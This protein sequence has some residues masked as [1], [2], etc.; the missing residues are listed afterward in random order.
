MK[1][2]DV[3]QC[4]QSVINEVKLKTGC[5]MKRRQSDCAT[6]SVDKTVSGSVVYNGILHERSVNDGCLYSELSG[7][8]VL[9]N[10]VQNREKNSAA[11]YDQQLGKRSP[12][13]HLRVFGCGAYVRA[14]GQ[15]RNMLDSKV[16]KILFVGYGLSNKIYRTYDPQIHEVEEVEFKESLLKRLVLLDGEEDK[17]V[18]KD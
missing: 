7:P 16:R 2:K 11:L 8:S 12:G 9:K 15:Y 4:L 18:F 6:E 13:G 3:F 14:P 17:W 5:T 1:R 10:H